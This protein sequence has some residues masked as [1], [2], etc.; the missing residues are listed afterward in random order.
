MTNL[1]KESIDNIIEDEDYLAEEDREL[2]DKIRGKRLG[3]RTRH[4][5]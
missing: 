1:I 2:L 5:L 4:L 3:C